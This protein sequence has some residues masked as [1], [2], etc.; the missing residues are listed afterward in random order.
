MWWTEVVNVEP[1]PTLAKF[2]YIRVWRDRDL[3]THGSIV[4]PPWVIVKL[5]DK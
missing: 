1:T 4:D 2:V 5:I 3:L